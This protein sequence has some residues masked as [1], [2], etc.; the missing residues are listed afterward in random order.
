MTNIAC[1]PP[2]VTTM[3]SGAYRAPPWAAMLSAMAV[4]SSGSP[5]GWV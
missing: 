5:S 1:C 2:G 4:R 3:S